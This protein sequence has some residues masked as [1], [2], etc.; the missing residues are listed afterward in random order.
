L[1]GSYPAF[2]LASFRPIAVLRGPLKS[3]SGGKILRSILVVVQMTVSVIIILATLIVYKQ[4]H[5]ML[6]K[7]LGFN[8]DNLMVISRAGALGE[9]QQTFIDEVKKLSWC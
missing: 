6:N 9:K 3:G 8:K 4:V 5:Y 7:D 1:A 2:F